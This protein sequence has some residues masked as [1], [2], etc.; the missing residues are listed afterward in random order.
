MTLQRD[1]KTCK[2][3]P[4]FHHFHHHQDQLVGLNNYRQ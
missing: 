1:E 3:E 2:K 4:C